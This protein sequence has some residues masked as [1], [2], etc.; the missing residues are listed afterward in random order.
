MCFIMEDKDTWL[1]LSKKS[2]VVF[3]IKSL[4]RK[5]I[6]GLRMEYKNLIMEQ[7]EIQVQWVEKKKKNAHNQR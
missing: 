1:S 2:L 3:Y 6:Q 5:K 7:N 4:I